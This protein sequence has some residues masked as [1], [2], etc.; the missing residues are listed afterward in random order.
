VKKEVKMALIKEKVE[1]DREIMNRFPYQPD[2]VFNPIGEIDSDAI[3]SRR[4][5]VENEAPS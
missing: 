4:D 3:L 5:R 1:A 2:Y